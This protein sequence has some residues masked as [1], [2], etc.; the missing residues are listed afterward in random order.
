MQ[1][2]AKTVSEHLQSLPEDRKKPIIEI[3]KALKNNLPNG[4]EEMM[5]Y[6]M[7]GYVVPLKLY[8]NGYH[9][10]PE[11]PLPFINLA[12]QK[13]YISLYHM[14]L[15]KGGLLDWFVDEWP[16]HSDQKLDMGKCCVRF[17]N[18]E[19]VPIDLIASLASKMNPQQWIAL[20]E[21][22]ISKST[23]RKTK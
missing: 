9:V 1:S 3:R 15:Y 14:A 13:N 22:T 16:V 17:K 10:D 12:S 20:Y 8:K 6:G 19:E 2:K 5:S 7:I 18:P 23:N 4:F 21:K 11:L